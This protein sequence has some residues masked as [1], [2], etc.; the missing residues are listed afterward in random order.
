MV[1]L[2]VGLRVSACARGVK[3]FVNGRAGFLQAG[4]IH[5]RKAAVINDLIDVSAPFAFGQAFGQRA[6]QPQGSRGVRRQ[7]GRTREA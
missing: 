3:R 2:I 7:I 1:I 4:W 5:C 6:L